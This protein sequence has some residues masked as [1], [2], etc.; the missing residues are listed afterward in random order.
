VQS[1]TKRAAQLTQ[2]YG[3]ID[4]GVPALIVDG[5]YLTMISMAGGPDQLMKVLDELIAKAR[6]E[7]GSN[8]KK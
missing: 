1:K 5:K 3:V 4:V 6:S 7:R 8:K 2:A